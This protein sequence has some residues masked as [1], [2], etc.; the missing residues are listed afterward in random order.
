MVFPDSADYGSDLLVIDG[1]Q[2]RLHH[3]AAG[4][5]KFRY[6]FD[7]GQTWAPWSVYEDVTTC[8]RTTSRSQPWK[9][10]H[11]LVQYW[12]RLAGTAYTTVHSDATFT[13]GQRRVPQYLVR[14]PFNTWGFDQGVNAKMTNVN[15]QWTFKVSST[16][17]LFPSMTLS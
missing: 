5:D 16:L 15:G 2:C 3:R 7:Y 1:A 8:N 13:G 12:S 14:G 10:A 6:S 4:A 9:G 17:R 11:V